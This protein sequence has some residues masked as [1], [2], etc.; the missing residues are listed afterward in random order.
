MTS[1]PLE[2]IRSVLSDAR[3]ELWSSW[4]S[5]M[6]ESDFND[7]PTIQDIDAEIE[8]LNQLIAGTHP[9]MVLVSRKL[10]REIGD[11][12]IEAMWPDGEV[13]YSERFDGPEQ[14]LSA[15]H[16]AMIEAAQKGGDDE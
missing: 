12:M 5:E 15:G 7:H 4:K 14:M 1:N 2:E 10:T 6:F 8:T 16:K 3:A 13:I 11:Q 9:D